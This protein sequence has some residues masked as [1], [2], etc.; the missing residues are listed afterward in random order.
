MPWFRLSLALIA[1]LFAA[2]VGAESYVLQASWPVGD[3]GFI[4]SDGTTIWSLNNAG[5]HVSHW[6]NTGARLG[7]W[8]TNAPSG[9]FAEGRGLGVDGAGNV[10][11]LTSTREAGGFLQEFQSDGSLVTGSHFAFPYSLGFA[12]DAS[13]TVYGG[14]NND[15]LTELVALG[16]DGT[17]YLRVVTSCCYGSLFGD[18]PGIS[19]IPGGITCGGPGTQLS[20]YTV[21]SAVGTSSNLIISAGWCTSSDCVYE[22]RVYRRGPVLLTTIPTEARA[23]VAA[24]GGLTLGSDNS[25]FVLTNS[26]TV[27]EWVPTAS[28]PVQRKSW[29]SVKVLWR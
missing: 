10:Y 24:A 1:I 29:G 15:D 9:T 25:L 20:C 26:K 12:V 14:D 21:T 8:D 28:T 23:G 7:G 2:P 11:V 18:G 3:A 6:S 4:V 22:T 13:G 19:M 16:S 5:T 27:E 17:R